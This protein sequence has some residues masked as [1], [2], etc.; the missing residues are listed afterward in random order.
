MIPHL[1]RLFF[2]PDHRILVPACVLGGGAY[3]VVCDMLA[4]VPADRYA[5]AAHL[6]QALVITSYSIHYT[7]LYESF[8]T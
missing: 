3:M 1:L 4:R 6:A 5:T 2:G 8:D 7:K